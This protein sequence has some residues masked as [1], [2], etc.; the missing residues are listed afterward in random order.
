MEIQKIDFLNKTII[1]GDNYL[2]E[3]IVSHIEEL[4]ETLALSSLTP[5]DAPVVR[6]YARTNLTTEKT[7]MSMIALCRVSCLHP[8]VTLQYF[9]CEEIEHMFAVL[10]IEK[11]QK[12]CAKKTDEEIKSLLIKLSFTL[13][14]APAVRLLNRR[15]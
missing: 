11:L 14:G 3:V 9:F 4:E 8:E 13:N 2:D 5:L 10:I 7:I 12:A 1:F 6:H 15:W